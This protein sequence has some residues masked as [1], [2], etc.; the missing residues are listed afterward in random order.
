MITLDV[1]TLRDRVGEEI[2]VGEWFAITQDRIDLAAGKRVITAEKRELLAASHPVEFRILRISIVP[3][4]NYRGCIFR[5][6]ACHVELL[7]AT[8]R[9]KHLTSLSLCLVCFFVA[10]LTTT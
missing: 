1:R 2:A 6:Y 7:W 9:H 4:E 10:T 5:N 8:K 3:E